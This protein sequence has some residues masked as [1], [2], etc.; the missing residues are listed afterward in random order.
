[1]FN[2]V[3]QLTC[4]VHGGSNDWLALPRPQFVAVC[5]R[6]LE[7]P[8]E[9]L[10]VESLSSMDVDAPPDIVDQY[11]HLRGATSLALQLSN[12]SSQADAKRAPYGDTASF[13]HGFFKATC[14]AAYGSGFSDQ[15]RLLQGS[16]QAA[17][18]LLNLIRA[19][20]LEEEDLGIFPRVSPPEI[21]VLPERDGNL[22]TAARAWIATLPRASCGV[23]TNACHVDSVVCRV[24]YVLIFERNVYSGGVDADE[25]KRYFTD[26]KE[27]VS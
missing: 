26:F 19:R 5:L 25:L 16:N 27:A 9:T 1:M 23:S 13:I 2:L 24:N 20:V 14:N 4:T 11:R 21:Y 6:L 7:R 10:T 18:D 12:P 8:I 3:F 17:A 15:E 22:L